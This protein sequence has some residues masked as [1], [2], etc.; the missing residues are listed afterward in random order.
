M[1]ADAPA[2]RPGL[3]RRVPPRRGGDPPPRDP[4]LH[5]R[6]QGRGRPP[7][8]RARRGHDEPL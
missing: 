3:D 7:A 4:R 1:S 5:E 8:D 2:Y 6:R